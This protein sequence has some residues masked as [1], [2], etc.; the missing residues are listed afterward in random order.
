M[1]EQHNYYYATLIILSFSHKDSNVTGNM[2]CY[3][4]PF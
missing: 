2:T 3:H 1:Q 4:G